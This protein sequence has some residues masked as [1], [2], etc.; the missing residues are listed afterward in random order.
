MKWVK[1]LLLLT[2]LVSTLVVLEASAEDTLLLNIPSTEDVI[3]SIEDKNRQE[4]EIQQAIDDAVELN[5]EQ[6]QSEEYDKLFDMSL[7]HTFIIE[8][9]QDEW[10][11]LINDMESY[12]EQYG[13]YRSNN[14]RS[15]TVTYTVGE[16]TYVI[17]DVG[18]RSKGNIYSRTLPEDQYGNVTEIHYMMKF[19]ETFDLEEG[20][21]EYTALKKREVFEQEQLLFKRN[22][23]NDPSYINEIFS[24]QL[25]EEAEVPVPKGTL[26]EVHIVIDGRV[27]NTHLYNV[28]EHFDEEFIRRY[29]QEIPTK[30]VGDLYKVSYSGTLEPIYDDY[31]YGF[32]DWE[33]NVRPIY[34]LETNKDNPNFEYLVQ[35]SHSFNQPNIND[36]KAFIDEYFN[37]DTFLRAMAI[38]VLTGNPD[39]Y[40]G[41]GNN[42]LFYFD[43]EGVLTYLPFDYDNSFGSGWAGAEGHCNYTLCNDIYDWGFLP[44]N[45]FTIPLWDNVIM[46][47]E[48]KIIYED[49]LM[50]FIESGIFSEDAYLDMF[51]MAEGHYGDDHVM[52]YDKQTFIREKIR[53]VTEDVEYYRNER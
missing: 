44:W 2:A 27:E 13:T 29:L 49:Y 5:Q 7:K 6:N 39:D 23:T 43:E 8:F 47:E 24:Y 42:F 12:Y 33:N 16:D 34:A 25:F 22:N 48:N 36:R 11:G 18:I 45:D 30:E 26:A 1:R 3:K 31:L 51:E 10:D 21:D 41:N 32:R 52:Y 50:E 14:Y 28:F 20:T 53:V 40:R 35:Y 19:N 15:V 17:E 4:E 9:T 46:F 37:V 38:N